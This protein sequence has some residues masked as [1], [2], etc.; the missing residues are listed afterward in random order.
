MVLKNWLIWLLHICFVLD[1]NICFVLDIIS[2]SLICSYTKLLL[3]TVLN[4]KSGVQ[5]NIASW[6]STLSVKG[7]IHMLIMRSVLEFLWWTISL[8]ALL[9]MRM[10]NGKMIASQIEL[11]FMNK[12]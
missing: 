10:L 2:M 7:K 11:S 4:R 5:L 12:Y 8:V 9:W 1:I 3:A 6:L